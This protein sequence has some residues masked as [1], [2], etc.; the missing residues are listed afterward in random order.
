L[1]EIAPD[2]TL[3]ELKKKTGVPFRVHEKLIEM[4]QAN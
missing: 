4:R 2:I 3:E 1:I